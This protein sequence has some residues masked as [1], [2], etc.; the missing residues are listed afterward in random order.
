MDPFENI[1]CMTDSYKVRLAAAPIVP[2]GCSTPLLSRVI[3]TVLPQRHACSG[4]SSECRHAGSEP[5]SVSLASWQVTHFMQYPPGTT[6]V[7]SYFE[8]RGGKFPQ[9][10]FYGLQY[11][12][13]RCALFTG[14][15]RGICNMR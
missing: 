9:T 11:M 10:V 6:K 13:K 1:I 4:S 7:F 14:P 3:H 5:A 2:W 8:S 15:S 12:I